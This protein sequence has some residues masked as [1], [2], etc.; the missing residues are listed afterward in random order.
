[1]LNALAEFPVCQQF[2]YN[3]YDADPFVDG[4][5]WTKS[6]PASQLIGA[7]EDPILLPRGGRRADHKSSISSNILVLLG[8]IH[9]L[10]GV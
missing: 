9:L 6:S 7:M 10:F 1:M 5:K 2:P 3:R 8:S 4:T